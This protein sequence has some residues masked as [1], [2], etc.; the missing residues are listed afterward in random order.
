MAEPIGV[1]LRQQPGLADVDVMPSLLLSPI[2]LPGIHLFFSNLAIL[3][4]PQAGCQI[5]GLSAHK[6]KFLNWFLTRAQFFHQI[7]LTS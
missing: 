5:E 3:N 2:I 7:R 1:A 6:A 4:I